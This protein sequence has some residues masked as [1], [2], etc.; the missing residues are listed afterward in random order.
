MFQLIK[1]KE[2]G[3]KPVKETEYRPAH[4]KIHS[5]IHFLAAHSNFRL[6]THLYIH[7]RS[8]YYKQYELRSDAGSVIFVSMV[9]SSL[10]CI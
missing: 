4:G 3:V 7:F 9:K 8:R 6:P 2:E 5:F 1:Q 10:K